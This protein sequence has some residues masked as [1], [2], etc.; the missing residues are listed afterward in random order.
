[1]SA[2]PL[3]R[4][5]VMRSMKT[6]C[7]DVGS[8]PAGISDGRGDRAIGKIL[9]LQSRSS[10]LRLQL[11]STWA[12]RLRLASSALCSC[13]S[14][15]KWP[16]L[17]ASGRVRERG[18]G[19]PTPALPRSQQAWLDFGVEYRGLFLWEAFVTGKAKS[20]GHVDDARA[21]VDAFVDALP[22]PRSSVQCKEAF[23]L[24]VPRSFAPDG[25]RTLRC[26]LNK[27]S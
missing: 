6:Y 26:S 9:E 15:A 8:I 7:A 19:A 12:A 24:M 11:T 2:N 16:I 23:S 3:D 27:S 20:K 10:D 17:G 13:R 5:E 22:D 18:L 1:V 21:A 14:V 25:R 4:N